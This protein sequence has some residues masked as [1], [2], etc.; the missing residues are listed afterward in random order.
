MYKMWNNCISATV[1]V[2][3]E[4][5][6]RSKPFHFKLKNFLHFYQKA[7]LNRKKFANCF[8]TNKKNPDHI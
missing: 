6:T 2:N 4:I 1:L 7:L 3:I 5:Y 8:F